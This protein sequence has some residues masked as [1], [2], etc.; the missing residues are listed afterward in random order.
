MPTLTPEQSNQVDTMLKEGKKIS[1]VRDYCKTTYA[2]DVPYA[3]LHYRQSKLKKPQ[4]LA[5][6]GPRKRRKYTKH[7][8]KQE[9]VAGGGVEEIV[10]EISAVLTQIHDGYKDIFMHLRKQLIESRNLV[11]RMK[12]N[13]GL[14]TEEEAQEVE[15]EK[16]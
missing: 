2:V 7:A 9:S 12:R 3:T 10:K 14:G 1:E 15:N 11:W 5:P 6:D 8:A 13:A 4:K 16:K